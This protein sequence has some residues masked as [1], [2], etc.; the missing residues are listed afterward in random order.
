MANKYPSRVKSLSQQVRWQLMWLGGGLFFA[1]L[2]LLVVFSWHSLNVITN[3]LMQLEAK[4]LVRIAAEY[5]DLS[6]PQGGTLSAYRKWQDIP[7]SLRSHFTEIPAPG[8]SI[9]VDIPISATEEELLTLLHHIDHDYGEI[10]LLSRHKTAE[11][12]EVLEIY[13]DML[14]KQAFWLSLIIFVSMFFLVRWLIRRTTEPLVML[15]LW[16]GKLGSNPDQPQNIDFPIEELN[17]LA[18][19]LRDGIDRIKAFNNREQQFLRHASHELRT[20]LAIIQASLDTLSLQSNVE[21]QRP[22]QRALRASANMS[23]MSA[24]LLWLARESEQPIDKYPLEVKLLCER[25]IT[26]HCYLLKNRDI[27]IK[28]IISVEVLEIEGDLFSILISN[29]VRNAFQYCA[30]GEISIEISASSLRISN[31]V[32]DEITKSTDQFS[33]GFGLGLELVQRICQKAGW[34]FS[35]NQEQNLVNVCVTW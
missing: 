3:G 7:E 19:Q 4:S 10:F 18:T 28:L 2:L 25:I 16:A 33:S 34:Q 26:D 30:D 20:P 14:L 27:D 1:F 9:E 8:Q 31:S 15:S 29:L 13:F 21:S 22:V 32:D 11:I 5:P 35:F 23:R 24:A 12:E 6:L 17:Q